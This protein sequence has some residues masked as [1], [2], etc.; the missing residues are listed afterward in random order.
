MVSVP[1]DAEDSLAK[2]GLSPTDI[3]HLCLSHLHFD[4][5]GDP[6]PYTSATVLVGAGGRPL[7]ETGYPHDPESLFD[8][9][10]LPEGRT[11]WLDPT[12][13]ASG[14]VWVPLGP[15]P[16]ALDLFGDGSLYI[17]DAGPGHVQGH[18]NVLART[19]ADGGWIFL[20]GDAAHDRRLL[21]GEARIPHHTTWGCAHRDAGA[22]E[23][24]IARIR[25][26]M[27]E[28]RVRVILAHDVPWYE[29]NKGGDAFWPGAIKPL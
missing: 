15:F 2:G 24:H 6:A 29:V 18:V 3:T 27:G 10:L 5:I 1:H 13:P 21:S 9:R 25:E 14:E 7:I 4:H 8:S 28:A 23:E 12:E 20:A 11:R 22:A 19:S 17:V 16:H 26:L